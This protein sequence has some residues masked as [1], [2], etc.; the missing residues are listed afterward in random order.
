MMNYEYTTAAIGVIVTMVVFYLMR[1]NVLYPRYA[2]WW[3]GC[4]V[5][6]LVLGLF[7]KISDLL[8][9]YA[10]VAYPPALIFTIALVLLCIK[11]LLMDIE[12]SRLES[13][14]R[15]LMQRN[16]ILHC[17]LKKMAKDDMPSTEDESE[18]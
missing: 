11:M 12:R 2:I 6:I 16:A 4:A 3:M 17:Q 8:A 15:R 9:G 5:G 10:G 7:P 14:L 1:R 18:I 13:R